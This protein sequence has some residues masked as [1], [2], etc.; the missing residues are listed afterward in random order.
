MF[1]LAYAILLFLCTLTLIAQESAASRPVA[2]GQLD[3]ALRLLDESDWLTRSVS[4]QAVCE[5]FDRLMP[6]SESRPESR[7]QLAIDTIAARMPLLLSC[8]TQDDPAV[9]REAAEV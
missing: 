9:L 6:S 8:L 4:L 3:E 1:R 5:A 2:L 7:S